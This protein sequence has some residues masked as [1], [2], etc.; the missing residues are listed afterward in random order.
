MDNIQK[1]SRDQGNDDTTGCLL[2]Y[3][4]LKEHYKITAIT[5]NKQ[6]ELD[7]DPKQYNRLILLE[8]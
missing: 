3:N 7:S 1:N 8:I 5:L 4:H 6:Q 2:D